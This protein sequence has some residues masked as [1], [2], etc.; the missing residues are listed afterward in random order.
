MIYFYDHDPERTQSYEY[1]FF[2]NQKQL[3]LVNMH[4]DRSHSN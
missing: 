1:E 3:S 2:I 4:P